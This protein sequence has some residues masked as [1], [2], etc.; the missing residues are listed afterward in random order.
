M[1]KIIKSKIFIS[2]FLAI[3]LAGLLF[4]SSSDP[5]YQSEMDI[6][7]I[8]KSP[9]TAQNADKIQN[10]TKEI[11]TS[12][13]FYDNILDKNLES[14]EL[15]LGQS[16][17]QRKSAWQ[18]MVSVEKSKNSNILK[19]FA[20]DKSR[21]KA[22]ALSQEVANQAS[23][24]MSQYYN[25]KTDLEIRIIDGPVSEKN[26]NLLSVS[27]WL[28]SLLFGVAAGLLAFLVFNSIEVVK[29]SQ[30]I[31]FRKLKPEEQ[32]TYSAS[33]PPI[34]L[35]E[36]LTSQPK[37]EAFVYPVEEEP[38]VFESEINSPKEIPGSELEVET[39]NTQEI[40]PLEDFFPI[41]VPKINIGDQ[42]LIQEP[43]SSSK[44]AAAPEN[45]PIADDSDLSFK[46]EEKSSETEIAEILEKAHDHN[47]HGVREATPAEVKARLNRLLK[48]DL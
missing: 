25:I 12:L 15:T 34:Y 8:P 44:K 10:D 39:E 5:V 32:K 1:Q 48:G 4:F 42:N 37:E 17:A 14:T 28:L 24:T 19:I 46:S 16:A 22:E 21:G 30:Q 41:E 43:V 2:F 20:L 18:K 6:L 26:L 29:N 38:Y 47:I 9:V 36:D 11:I 23:E 3:S 33:L 31:V 35:Q 45:L 27:A 7:L 13:N 40:F